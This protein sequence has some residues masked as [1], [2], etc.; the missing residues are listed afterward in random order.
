MHTYHIH[1]KGIVQGVGFRPFVYALATQY[2]LKGT[3]CNTTDGV[4]IEINSSK[5]IAEAFLQ[6]IIQQKPANA[7]I[8]GHFIEFVPEK[9][10]SD[11]TIIES[12]NHQKPDLLLT[13]DIAICEAC[14]KEINDK[15]NRR[16]KY[17][18]TTC[19]NCG[20]RYSIINQ[21]PYDRK[22]TT[23]QHLQMCDVC[24]TE[25][26]NVHD[27][28]HYS[29]TNSCS[30]CAI[31]I[32]LYN[33]KKIKISSNAAEIIYHTKKYF[34][35]GKILAVK[36]IGGFL[37]MCDATNAAAIKLLRERKQRPSK[38]FAVMYDSI[39]M[40]QQDVHLRETEKTALLGKE[41]PIVLCEMKPHNA[42]TIQK[43]LITCGLDTLGV[44]LPYTPLLKLITRQFKKPLIATSG[45]LSGSPIIYKDEDA[46]QWLFAFA[47][48][49]ITFDREIVAPQDDSV[50][51]FSASEQK[52]ILRRS[53]GLS[54]NY[55]PNPFHAETPVLA[56]G[57][58]LKG[59]FALLYKNLYISQFLGDQESY[60]SQESYKNTLQHL[61][62]LLKIVPQKII[63]D[64][65]PA[66]NVSVLGKEIAAQKH[67]PIMEVQ[68]HI[69]H[70]FAV[71][72]EN[73]LLKNEEKILGV[74]WD[75][76][77][78]GDDGQIWGGE[79][80]TLQK[81]EI[82]RVAH[83]EY[84][85]Q[86]MGDKMSK[87]PRL[88]AMAICEKN[89]DVVK[90]NFSNDEFEL[91]QKYMNIKEGLKTSSMGRF[92]DGIAS[93][94]NILQHNSYEGEAAMKLETAAKKSPIKHFE[95]YDIA[96]EKGIIIWEKMVN[97]I[98]A[99]KN[100]N[101]EITYIARK[102]FVSLVRMIEY[103]ASAVGV[104]KIAF[105][106]GVFQ[107]RLLIDLIEEMMSKKY[108]LIFHQQLSPNDECISF[109]QLAYYEL[110]RKK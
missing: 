61:Q 11:F 27:R 54:P 13:P 87:E 60:E 16:Y 24:K 33:H 51:Q 41:A 85:P 22:N 50:M 55:F 93:L 34:G 89:P 104:H 14:K 59:A 100:K 97:G 2:K 30:D 72:A 44:F 56:M 47:D 77:G 43:N 42:S 110:I 86:L 26:N 21:L 63:I 35:E 19:L 95:N 67:L 84:F 23:M 108:E 7:L 103:V 70:F 9:F 74:I 105:S 25:Y 68:H 79:F 83:L 29:Q 64:K 81:N 91:F 28:R 32:Y 3:V 48:Y 12:K 80:F 94:L 57:A 92:L 69:A 36:G 62:H 52:I 10:F 101:L 8:T 82:E 75:G 20:P 4:H 71:L 106:G 38:P 5:K 102:V 99:D 17:V 98:L 45:N 76:T 46:L 58:E 37:L 88:S 107:N 90:N 78:Y 66:Y 73:N 53:R 40:M 39:E 15:K 49:C 96:F 6:I 1:I 65:H 31:P 18:F 109:G